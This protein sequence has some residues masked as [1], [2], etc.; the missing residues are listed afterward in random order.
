MDI[1]VSIIVP[2]YNVEKYL[3]ICIDSIICQTL[4]EIEIICVDDGSTD[5]SSV[6]LDQYAIKDERI[7]VVHKKNG[8]YGKAVNIGMDLAQG[9]YVGIVDSDD[10][11][12][13]EMYEILYMNAKK[14]N[15]DMIKSDFFLVYDEYLLKLHNSKLNDYYNKVLESH[16]RK[17]YYL[18]IMNTWTGIYKRKFIRENSIKHNETAG[19]SYQDNGFWIQTVS[20]CN[21]AMWL[22]QAFYMHRL[23]NPFAST[24]SK[25]KMLAM[26]N[27]YDFAGR[28]LKEKNLVNQYKTC[29]YYRMSRHKDT[30]YRIN[31]SLK[32]EYAII[33]KNDYKKYKQIVDWDFIYKQDP[34]S[35]WI[36]NLANEPDRVCDEII[37]NL[38]S[39]SEL[40]KKSEHIIIYGT[41]KRAFLTCVK[42]KLMGQFHKI[43]F[44]SV[45]KVDGKNTF[46]GLDVR[47]AEEII[48]YK[49]DALILI[50]VVKMSQAYREI[51]E[52]LNNLGIDNYW[53]TELISALG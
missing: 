12:L 29:N 49:D 52:L 45:S 38:N 41:G 24:K 43:L 15:L 28:I 7:K 40:I 1:K 17:W 35:E 2:V 31:D 9:E 22:D 20:M 14:N 23:D 42:L 44:A 11:I 3:P 46:F 37:K 33:I 47:N 13:P 5:N 16:Y 51:E 18:F 10:Y 26:L 34:L 21:N 50:S 27:E 4:R 32:K 25:E 48:P 19:A 36:E 8:G 30:F 6:I 39:F 53:D